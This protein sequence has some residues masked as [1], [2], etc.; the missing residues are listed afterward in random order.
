[1]EVYKDFIQAIENKKLIKVKFN[2]DE[3]GPVERTCIPVDFLP[4][5]KEKDR[6]SKYCVYD[7]DDNAKEHK[8]MIPPHQLIWLDLVEEK[9]D[10]ACYL[11]E[12]GPFNWG[13]QRNWGAYS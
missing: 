1:M 13:V 8:L 12:A 9:F 2:S 10:P 6:T 7:L 4:S 3:K 11:P 5:N